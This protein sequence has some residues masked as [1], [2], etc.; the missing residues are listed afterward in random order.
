M[1]FTLEQEIHENV[2]I[3]LIDSS[4]DTKSDMDCAVDAIRAFDEMMLSV[5]LFSDTEHMYLLVNGQPIDYAQV[6]NEDDLLKLLEVQ[7]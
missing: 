4:I 7:A 1:K 3:M 6:T 2:R 5:G